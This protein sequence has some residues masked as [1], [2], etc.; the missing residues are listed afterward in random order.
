MI[1]VFITCK[2]AREAGKIG[3]S[4]VKKRLAACSVVIPGTASF[5]WWPPRKNKIEKSREAILLVK[6]VR[7]NFFSI[8]REV[9]MLHSY[10]VPS[11]L[12]VSVEK[13]HTPYLKWL[14][15]ELK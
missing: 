5:Y 8:E 14:Q 10:T 13:A 4:L 1:L 9:E 6:T 12:A 7:N 3:L 2:N 15:G 11:I